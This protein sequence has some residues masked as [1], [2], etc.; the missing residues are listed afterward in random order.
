MGQG[1]ACC[2]AGVVLVLSE[3]RV[4]LRRRIVC[5]ACTLTLR[6]QRRAQAN[7]SAKIARPAGITTVAGP[8]S[9]IIAIPT[10][11][12]V[13]PTMATI[14]RLAVLYVYDTTCWFKGVP[15]CRLRR[16]LQ[17]CRPGCYYCY[18]P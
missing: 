9:T 6:N 8:G 12:T 3:L 14:M 4:W 18:M 7:S 10:S 17:K 13:P 15:T 16:K 5:R 1:L 2:R 11:K